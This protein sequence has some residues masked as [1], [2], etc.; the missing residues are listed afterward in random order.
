M[1]ESPLPKIRPHHS[2][3]LRRFG[4]FHKLLGLGRSLRRLDL[5]AASIQR[6]LTANQKGP[7]VYVLLRSS[8]LDYLALN[9]V[10]NERRLPLGVWANDVSHKWWT[11]WPD[12]LQAMLPGRSKRDSQFSKSWLIEQITAG[13]SLTV[14]LEPF[15]GQQHRIDPLPVLLS[16]QKTS[17]KPVQLI[18]VVVAWKRAPT[19][20]VN[21]SLRF[22]MD[23]TPITSTLQ[24]VMNVVLRSRT[25]FVQVGEPVELTEVIKRVPEPRQTRA[26]RL[27]LRRYIK[28]ETNVIRG[29]RLLSRNEMMRMVLNSPSMRKLRA[30][31]AI[32][33]G[34]NEAQ[35]QRKMEREY[36]HLAA[37]FRYWMIP[38]LDLVLRPLWTK[39]YSGVDIPPED[40]ER[41]R[42]AMRKGSVVLAPCH[43][44][45]FDYVLIS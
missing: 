18:P 37:R 36:N 3:M 8:N 16:A 20:A 38:V 2:S 17:S 19:R 9:H 1:N 14:C 34:Q 12:M 40:L 33:S 39:V 13:H 35:I 28:R 41:I 23:R 26:L 10:L 6:I 31:E 42:A 45:H 4:W 25:A 24:Q 43:K 5:D 29:P 27:L 22:L 11:T 32:A 30:E 15:I 44:S 7:I 21:P